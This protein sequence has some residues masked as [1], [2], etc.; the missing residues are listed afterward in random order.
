MLLEIHVQSC[1]SDAVTM[2]QDTKEEQQDTKEEDTLK[3]ST[4]TLKNYS[5]CAAFLLSMSDVL[6][7]QSTAILLG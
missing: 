7:L 4:K 2:K 3:K 1:S 6:S 5:A